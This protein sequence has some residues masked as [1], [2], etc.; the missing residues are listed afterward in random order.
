[1][2]QGTAEGGGPAGGL[3]E[4]QHVRSVFPETWLW[5]NA[6][7]RGQLKEGSMQLLLID[8]VQHAFVACFASLR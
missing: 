6:S 2:A 3:H 5:A 4:V 1:M 8:L 7:V